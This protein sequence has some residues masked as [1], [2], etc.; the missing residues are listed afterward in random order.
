MGFATLTLGGFVLLYIRE[1]WPFLPLFYALTIEMMNT[2]RVDALSLELE[3]QKHIS[4]SLDFGAEISEFTV[5]ELQAL[6]ASL[7]RIVP[8]KRHFRLT[9]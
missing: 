8:V 4:D 9:I 1:S 2:S 6:S 5:C 3:R 7:S